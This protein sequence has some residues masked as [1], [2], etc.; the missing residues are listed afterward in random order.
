MINTEVD[1]A[2]MN[3]IMRAY[4][5][6]FVITVSIRDEEFQLKDR[7]LGIRAYNLQKIISQLDKLTIKKDIQTNK[8]ES[9]IK[10]KLVINT[11]KKTENQ[12]LILSNNYEKLTKAQ[13]QVFELLYLIIDEY[14]RYCVFV[15]KKI[16]D[17]LYI[18]KIDKV[19][20]TLN[21]KF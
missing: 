13:K 16:P 9:E 6:C 7:I 21:V 3:A 4:T 8:T 19:N 12:I 14:K 2:N 1:L 20:Y 18:E 11:M 10:L 5:Y 15:E 17:D